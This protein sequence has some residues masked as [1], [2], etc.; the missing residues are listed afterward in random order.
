MDL[1][2][3]EGS[4]KDG[5]E[6]FFARLSPKS[7]EISEVLLF[8]LSAPLEKG[9]LLLDKRSVFFS[10]IVELD[11]L[12]VGSEIL[13]LQSELN[14]IKILV[15]IL[16]MQSVVFIIDDLSGIK[17]VCSYEMIIFEFEKDKV[18]N[19]KTIERRILLLYKIT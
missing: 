14:R 3:D 16:L 2:K 17:F 6:L 5:E 15:I 8:L 13:L 4:S 18:I 9:L 7:S 11:L 1:A 10:L 12:L 19:I